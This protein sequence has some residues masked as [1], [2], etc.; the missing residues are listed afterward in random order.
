M[1][2]HSRRVWPRPD[3]LLAMLVALVV[4]PLLASPGLHDGLD[5]VVKGRG[6]TGA[7]GDPALDHAGRTWS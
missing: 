6:A 1:I 5:P 2:E 7:A 3:S 4:V